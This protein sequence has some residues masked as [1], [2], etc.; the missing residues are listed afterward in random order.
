MQVKLQN[1]LPVRGNFDSDPAGLQQSEMEYYLVRSRGILL[2]P[3]EASVGIAL[4][5][6]KK[7]G[8]IMKMS[9]AVLPSSWIQTVSC[10]YDLFFIGGG[11]IQSIKLNSHIE[12][13]KVEILCDQVGI[14]QLFLKWLKKLLLILPLTTYRRPIM[15]RMDNICYAQISDAI[16]SPKRL[17][18]KRKKATLKS[19]VVTKKSCVS[20]WIAFRYR[21]LFSKCIVLGTCFHRF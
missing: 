11:N 19:K 16:K 20:I 1:K 9:R 6:N 14:R 13:D 2:A 10:W 5:K 3:I 7:F 21:W 18:K 15:A 8:P 12:L 17:T 4:Q